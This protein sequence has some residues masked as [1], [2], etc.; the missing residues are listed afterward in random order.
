MDRDRGEGGGLGLGRVYEIALGWLG[1]TADELAV[2]TWFE[3][4]CKLKG[5][6]EREEHRVRT[7]WEQ[8]RATASAVW[9]TVQW[10]NNQPPDARQVFPLP[11]DPAPKVVEVSERDRALKLLKAKVRLGAKLRPDQFEI[12]NRHFPDGKIPEGEQ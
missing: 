6:L 3:F 5:Y 8:T 10:K 11:W 12:V 2:S 4:N 1:M 9:M 7:S